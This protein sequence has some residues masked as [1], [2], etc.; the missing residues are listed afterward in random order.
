[1]R[2]V[3]AAAGAALGGADNPEHAYEFGLARLLDGLGVPIAERA[4]AVGPAG[5]SGTGRPVSLARR[6]ERA[7]R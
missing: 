5:A 1:V 6:A 4:K 7:G 2:R 3:G